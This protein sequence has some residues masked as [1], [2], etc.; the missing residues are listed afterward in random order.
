MSSEAIFE[1]SGG[2]GESYYLAEDGRLFALSE[3]IPLSADSRIQ[4]IREIPLSS[5]VRGLPLVREVEEI[6]I[7]KLPLPRAS[8][9]EDVPLAAAGGLHDVAE[10]P[11]EGSTQAERILAR[12]N[13]ASVTKHQDTNQKGDV[14]SLRS[15]LDL[16]A[17]PESKHE[18]R[19][20]SLPLNPTEAAA[21]LQSSELTGRIS[22]PLPS[23][24]RG[25]GNVTSDQIFYLKNDA[26]SIE[27]FV[28]VY[29]IYKCKACDFSSCQKDDL[30]THIKDKHLNAAPM[31]SSLSLPRKSV[32]RAPKSDE[33]MDVLEVASA[34]EKED[35][36]AA[37][38]INSMLII[39]D[40]D[41]VKYNLE[42]RTETVI[43]EDMPKPTSAEPYFKFFL[44]KEQKEIFICTRCSVC[45]ST[46]ER[47]KVHVASDECAEPKQ[48]D[49]TGALNKVEVFKISNSKKQDEGDEDTVDDPVA[50]ST[51]QEEEE[52]RGG[53]P[54][55]VD[56]LYKK[57]E[58]DS[59]DNEEGGEDYRITRL[60]RN[61][62]DLEVDGEARVWVCSAK[63]CYAIFKMESSLDYHVRC[64]RPEGL[65]CPEEACSL[66]HKRFSRWGD[67]SWH[68]YMMHKR[69]CDLYQCIQCL[70]YVTGNVMSLEKHCQ[71]HTNLKLHQCDVC[72]KG[73]NQQVQLKNHSIVHLK[74]NK[75][76]LPNWARPKKCDICKK[77][78]SDSKS[79]KKHVQAVHSQL[80]PYICQICGYK[81][82]RK[83]NLRLHVRQHSGEKPFQCDECEYRTGDHNSL[84]RHKKR[85]TGDKPYKCT[86]CPF[87][88]IQSNSYK[89]HLKFKHQIESDGNSTIKRRKRKQTATVKDKHSISVLESTQ[90]SSC[91]KQPDIGLTDSLDSLLA[92]DRTEVNLLSHGTPT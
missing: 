15:L 16:K 4:E 2:D 55:I 8:S 31:L 38:N 75:A 19:L 43:L 39:S 53:S 59:A 83:A 33:Q 50:L 12:L 21:L 27:D 52:E 10:L 68:L 5:E 77:E 51:I 36:D 65:F 26:L 64:H 71:T 87:S 90:A 61:R 74:Q 72:Y 81:S 7:E 32:R 46:E 60:K 85:H 86:L 35:E 66:S 29:T 47:I 78:F 11:G 24:G 82:A 92:L 76:N 80:K 79:L 41:N 14:V 67:L 69:D 57:I 37:G 89:S 62:T 20:A 28:E 63:F 88:C 9:V 1:D 73:F 40:V 49:P 48:A 44:V 18:S 34:K 42:G 91:A 84:R 22:I 25:G 45:M 30:H 23:S 56:Q 17:P 54:S 3:N 58:E 70:T 13:T 6:A